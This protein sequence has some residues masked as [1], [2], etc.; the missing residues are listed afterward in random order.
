MQN[1]ELKR[2]DA[3]A[4]KLNVREKKG[5]QLDHEAVFPQIDVT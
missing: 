4:N 5:K 2:C 1:L 3:Y